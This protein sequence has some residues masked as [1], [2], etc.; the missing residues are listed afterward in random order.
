MLHEPAAP[1]G[2][3]PAFAYKKRLGVILF[4]VYGAIYAAFVIINIADASLMEKTLFGGQNL[5]VVYGFGLI[6]LALLLA[7]AYNS[8]CGKREKAMKDAKGGKK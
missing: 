6:V 4:F 5:A 1:V 2:K 7:L 8:A 3:D